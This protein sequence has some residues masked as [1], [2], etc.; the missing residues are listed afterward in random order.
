MDLPELKIKPREGSY[1][2]GQDSIVQI[3]SAALNLLIEEGYSALSLR[4]IAKACDM[5]VG[6]VTYYFATKDALVREMLSAAIEGYM[7]AFEDVISQ[8]DLTPEEKLEA[9]IR[10]ILEDIRTKKT[11]RLFPELWALANFDPFVAE[12][13][14]ESYVNA[15][16]A[17]NVLVAEIN[18][19]LPEEERE[20]LCLF[21]S[22]ALEGMTIFAGYQ[23]PWEPKMP[24]IENIAVRSLINFVKDAKP[25]DI[26]GDEEDPLSRLLS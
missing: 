12:C 1:A 24:W 14:N 4:R 3:L 17:L 25:E 9:I 11:T 2:R 15:R 19:S 5:K 23:K 20:T 10:I 13:V 21:I 22:G 16:R 26:H 8:V 18:P 6:N 7:S